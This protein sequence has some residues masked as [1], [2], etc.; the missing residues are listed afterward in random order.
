MRCHQNEHHYLYH[1]TLFLLQFNTLK[2][3][4]WIKRLY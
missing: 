3:Q 1:F 4:E 2:N